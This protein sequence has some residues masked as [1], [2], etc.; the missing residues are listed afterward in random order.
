MP[1][2]VSAVKLAISAISVTFLF[3]P[4]LEIDA[5]GVWSASC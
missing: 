4:P 3:R 1:W 5:E 2:E